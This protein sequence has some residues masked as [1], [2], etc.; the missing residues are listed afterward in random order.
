MCVTVKTAVDLKPEHGYLMLLEILP[1]SLVLNV[2]LSV[3]ILAFKHGNGWARSSG[4]LVVLRSSTLWVCVF[5]AMKEGFDIL[6]WPGCAS[7]QRTSSPIGSIPQAPGAWVPV[8][9]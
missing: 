1:E 8:R 5:H 9:S 6:V 4:V 3:W 7:G 2:D